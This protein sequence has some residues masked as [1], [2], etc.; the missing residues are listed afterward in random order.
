[1]IKSDR[2]LAIVIAGLFILL[3]NSQIKAHWI[4]KKVVLL[5]AST[6]A[7]MS[8]VWMILKPYKSSVPVYNKNLLTGLE[9][10]Y[11][12]PEVNA[13]KYDEVPTVASH[14]SFSYPD[15]NIE[16]LSLQTAILQNQILNIKEQLDFGVRTFFIDVYT[17]KKDPHAPIKFSHGSGGHTRAFTRRWEFFLEDINHFLS[18]TPNEI[19]TLHL[20][21]YVENYDKIMRDLCAA[22]LDTY[23]YF[24]AKSSTDWD[25]REQ[26][27]KN[28]QRL[29]V[30]SDANKDCGPGIMNTRDYVIENHYKGYECVY[31]DFKRLKIPEQCVNSNRDIYQCTKDSMITHPVGSNNNQGAIIFVMNHFYTK[32]NF[33]LIKHRFPQ[34]LNRQKAP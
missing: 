4:N 16:F 13:K 18:S 31:R 26:M 8:V 21:S 32:S 3:A 1:M 14:N 33:D 23:L 17:D 28:N 9:N 15:K 10:F 27:I 12:D 34:G 6:S 20:E 25:T 22:R 2:K 11:N 5:S 30:F 19:I 29:L 24:A 7:L